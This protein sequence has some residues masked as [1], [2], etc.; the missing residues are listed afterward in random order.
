MAEYDSSTVNYGKFEKQSNAPDFAR[1]A[2]ADPALQAKANQAAQTAEMLKTFGN[3]AMGAYESKVRKDRRDAAEARRKEMEAKQKLARD[4]S[5]AEIR[6]NE[7]QLESGGIA[8]GDLSTTEKACLS[9]EPDIN[10]I[11][12]QGV[13]PSKP[14]LITKDEPN[15]ELVKA[16]Y[17][18]KNTEAAL[19]REQI[20]FD[21]ASPVLVTS[22]RQQFLDQK[23]LRDEDGNIIGVQSWT[24]YAAAKLE[25]YKTEQGQVYRGLPQLGAA[26]K[27]VPLNYKL[28]YKNVANY[29]REDK[30][31]K[32]KNAISA[33][34]GEH[35]PSTDLSKS[36]NIMQMIQD[37]SA[38][39]SV[40]SSSGEAPGS[41]SASGPH[42]SGKKISHYQRDVKG[43]IV[44]LYEQ[45]LVHK[46]FNENIQRRGVNATSSN[47]P[48]F[49]ILD[50]LNINKNPKAMEIFNRKKGVGESYQET[51]RQL[52]A[53][54]LS[55][56]KSEKTALEASDKKTIVLAKQNAS[57]FVIRSQKA[58]LRS[59]LSSGNLAETQGDPELGQFVE[60]RTD[61]TS[62]NRP[63]K[64]EDLGNAYITLSKSEKLF[65]TA[66]MH[67]AWKTQMVAITAELNELDPNSTTFNVPEDAEST[68][69][70]NEYRATYAKSSLPDLKKAQ[71]ELNLDP[72][73]KPW[74]RAEKHKVI[75]GLMD[76][77]IKFKATEITALNLKSKELSIA[78]T[79]KEL[80]SKNTKQSIISRTRV[81]GVTVDAKGLKA[82][83]KETEESDMTNEDKIILAEKLGTIIDTQTKAE[84][85]TKDIGTHAN[86]LK[87][88][89]SLTEDGKFKSVEEIQKIMDKVGDIKDDT[90]RS[91]MNTLLAARKLGAA[92]FKIAQENLTK[93]VKYKKEL[94]KLTSQTDREINLIETSASLPKLLPNGEKNPD[95][96]T[97]DQ[98]KQALEQLES[99]FF[100]PN[101][102][103]GKKI[104]E[105]NLL[106]IKGIDNYERFSKGLAAINGQRSEDEIAADNLNLSLKAKTQDKKREE[107]K[108]KLRLEIVNI[109]K[110]PL[111]DAG[112]PEEPISGLDRLYQILE[113]KEDKIWENGNKL[114]GVALFDPEEKAKIILDYKVEETLSKKPVAISDSTSKIQAF[115]N[116][117][118]IKTLTGNNADGVSKRQLAIEAAET[119]IKTELTEGRLSNADFNSERIKLHN[120]AEKKP[121]TKKPVTV[122]EDHIS[123]IF[124]GHM[125]KWK[126]NKKWLERGPHGRLN[127]DAKLYNLLSQEYNAQWAGLVEGELKGADQETLTREAIKLAATFT[128]VYAN[129]GDHPV[130]GANFRLRRYVMD[131]EELQ[132]LVWD[133]E[134]A[135]EA[136]KKRIE[137]E[138]ARK[139]NITIVDKPEQSLA[140]KALHRTIGNPNVEAHG[141]WGTIVEGTSNFLQGQDTLIMNR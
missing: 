113:A 128:K 24:E 34:I 80:G 66:G 31:E 9:Q 70:V 40:D 54:K 114:E 65:A 45:E 124:A 23:D 127:E 14:K 115:E 76:Q 57:L 15:Y 94:L 28:F 109:T 137:E 138:N 41:R 58:L 30:L 98:A 48:V 16:A 11:Q 64:L 119:Y 91:Q 13:A 55:L 100:D 93:E 132:Q 36:E 19:R 104:A 81:D 84:Q 35:L 107:E 79:K 135:A 27:N 39:P 22:L 25:V 67:E 50:A 85:Y 21:E 47:D 90:L 103:T 6:A 77:Q 99:K 60:Q 26:G 42:P 120:I 5:L 136:E 29:E 56:M 121:A 129:D 49:K 108:S 12:N 18:R 32:K 59:N 52:K 62:V 46:Q 96:R 111:A 118:E 73:L 87:E 44:R 53:K 95:Y 110:N 82:L 33:Q 72:T 74:E 86:M 10:E 2:S 122:G 134:D 105:G 123:A 63:S 78:K 125:S 130:P 106:N 89:T 68:N 140:S 17:Q 3:S 38:V 43:R 71:E 131:K 8:F 92:E 88:A 126:D 117:Q 4:K 141:L 112:D 139:K 51:V 61:G 133:E 83:L 101:S 97:I 1:Y 69:I 37:I 20:E 102:K 7:L 116:I 75:D